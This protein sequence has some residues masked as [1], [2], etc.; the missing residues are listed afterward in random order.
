MGSKIMHFCDVHAFAGEDETAT[1]LD[2]N[3]T[4]GT[5]E[6]RLDLCDSCS[7]TLADALVDFFDAGVAPPKRRTAK[8][9]KAE[10][11]FACDGCDR[12]FTTVRGRSKHVSTA[13]G[14]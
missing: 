12:R 4:L 8:K 5:S 14:R 9:A 10:A 13:H 11:P 2:V 1:V 3:L 6:V 7:N